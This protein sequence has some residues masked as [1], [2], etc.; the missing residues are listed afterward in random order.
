M[1]LNEAKY[2][3]PEWLRNFVDF[4]VNTGEDIK[5]EPSKRKAAKLEKEKQAELKRQAEEKVDADR[6]LKQQQQRAEA[7]KREQQAREDSW[8]KQADA[9]EKQDQIEREINTL[10]R[11]MISDFSSARYSDKITTPQR[12]GKTAFYYTFENGKIMR[13]YKKANDNRYCLEWEGHIYTLGL[14]WTGKFINLANEMTDKG[15]ARPRRSGYDRYD[16]Y[17]SKSSSGSSGS[18]GRSSGSSQRTSST[19]PK[20]K[21]HPKGTMY[22]NLKDTVKLR[23]EQLKRSSGSDREALQNELNAAKRML[24]NLNKKYSFE[25]NIQNFSQFNQIFEKSKFVETDEFNELLDKI[26]DTGI[27]SLTDIEKKRL[28]LFSMD[29]EPILDIIDRMA[30]LTSEFKM[31]NKKIKQLSDEG[32]TVEAK[33]LFRDKWSPMNDEMIK[34][35]REIK[36]YGIEVGDETFMSLMNKHRS[37]VYGYDVDNEGGDELEMDM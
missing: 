22:Q 37:D 8:K 20:W 28:D 23:E 16:S 27:T 4:E 11:S 1:K 15:G 14:V 32:K 12:N 29:D 7:N 2:R 5:G 31:V 36:S 21:D 30:D 17:G 9:K 25:S 6:K 19:P 34:L 33:N 26:N 3:S 35:E 10:Y 18:S 13:M 24:D